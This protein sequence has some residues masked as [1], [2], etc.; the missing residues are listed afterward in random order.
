MPARLSSVGEVALP[1]LVGRVFDVVIDDLHRRLPAAGFDD[2]R[3]AHC[4]GVLRVIDVDG[5]RPTELARRADVTPQAMAEMVGYLEGRGYVTR[6]DDPSDGRGRIVR[7]TAR[8]AQAVAAAKEALRAI[9]TEW[10]DRLDSDRVVELKAT[11][12]ELAGH[13]SA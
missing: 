6:D 10:S 1:A 3:P 12:A 7:P 13:G 11:L 2:I 4:I 8:G 5:T 9:E